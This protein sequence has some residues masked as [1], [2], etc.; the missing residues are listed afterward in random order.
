MEV[1]MKVI[2]FKLPREYWD[3]LASDDSRNVLSITNQINSIF[4]KFGFKYEI[5]GVYK[6]KTSNPVSAVLAAQ[7]LAREVYL[8]KDYV[9]SF[10]MYHVSEEDSFKP[11]LE[12][13]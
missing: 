7:T 13:I 2:Q 4:E 5:E 3:K 10:K 11:V 12:N 1:D 9:T 8:F 6:S